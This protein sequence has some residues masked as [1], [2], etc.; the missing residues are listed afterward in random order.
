MKWCSDT[1]DVVSDSGLHGTRAHSFPESQEITEFLG[2]HLQR[3]TFL[4][5][6]QP[7]HPQKAG[8]RTKCIL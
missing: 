1:K 8:N 6:Q 3:A 2:P 4:K 7:D 5:F